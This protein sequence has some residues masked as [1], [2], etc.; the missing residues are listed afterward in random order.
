M[1][2]WCLSCVRAAW[3]IATHE[4]TVHVKWLC[5]YSLQKSEAHV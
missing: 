4:V 2:Q 1:D 5:I 3:L